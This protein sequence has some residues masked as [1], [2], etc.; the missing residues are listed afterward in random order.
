MGAMSGPMFQPR[1]TRA[2][3]H[4][5]LPQVR[6]DEQEMEAV[7]WLLRRESAKFGKELSIADLLRL[8]VDHLYQAEQA[9][10]AAEQ[11]PAKPAPAP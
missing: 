3:R 7:R 1:G 8:A 5:V 6:V 4:L 9:A 11:L 10:A 2:K